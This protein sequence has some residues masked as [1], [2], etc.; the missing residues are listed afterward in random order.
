MDA[1]CDILPIAEKAAPLVA[2]LLKDSR[3]AIV[4]GLLGMLVNCD[5]N[6]H[7]LLAQKLKDDPD[8]YA[9]LKNLENTHAD[10]LSKL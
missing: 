4:V 1:L 6:D 2:S 9:K 8:L 10:W 7:E 3:I 5:P